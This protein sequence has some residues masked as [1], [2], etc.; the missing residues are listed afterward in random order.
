MT[1]ITGSRILPILALTLNGLLLSPPVAAQLAPHPAATPAPNAPAPVFARVEGVEISGADYAVALNEAVRQKFYH[2]RP[3][4]AEVNAVRRQVGYRMI[5]DIL[6]EREAKKLGIQPDTAAVDKQLAEYEARYKDSES[7]KARRESVLPGLRAKLERDSLRDR[8]EAHVKTLPEPTRDEVAGYYEA[9]PD[10]F[11]EPEQVHLSMILLKVDPS[12]SSE[13][14]KL[15]MEEGE[16]LV[17]KVKDGEDFAELAVLHSADISAERGGDLGY[18]HRGMIPE[19]LSEQLDDLPDGAVSKPTR[20]LEGI[21]TFKIH[22]RKKA[23]H[24]SLE[25]VYQRASEL[26]ARD[27]A[28]RTWAEYLETLPTRYAVEINTEAFPYFEEVKG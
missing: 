5:N 9:N 24:H 18:I 27:R 2:G 28:E 20:I 14:W 21:A 12:S 4:E 3:P 19:G 1:R 22:G 11:T 26:Y 13:I 6:F 25:R 16:K 7:W 8:L 23:V 15:A 10:K 17:S